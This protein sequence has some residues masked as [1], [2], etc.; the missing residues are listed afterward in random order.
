M[1]RPCT[2]PARV[3]RR[4]SN[5]GVIMVAGQKIALGRVHQHQTVTVYVAEVTMTIEFG[6]SDTRV[7][8][9]TTETAVRSIKSQRPR[10]ATK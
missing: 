1:P 10:T 3:Q 5:T 4:A 6:D 7:V 9:R 8:R 2:E